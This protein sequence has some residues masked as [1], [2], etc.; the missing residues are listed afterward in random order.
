MMVFLSLDR[1]SSMRV[2]MYAPIMVPMVGI[3][4]IFQDSIGACCFK[5]KSYR[6]RLAK[7][8]PILT[9]SHK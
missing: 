9:L 3:I 2:M 4:S 7:G 8:S 5:K 6:Y 1:R